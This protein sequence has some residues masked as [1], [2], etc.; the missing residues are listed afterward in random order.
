[1]RVAQKYMR[2]FAMKFMNVLQRNVA[3]CNSGEGGG[4]EEHGK[5]P[6]CGTID[7]DDLV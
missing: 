3:N 6:V 4:C 5:G 1:M 2:R 7:D